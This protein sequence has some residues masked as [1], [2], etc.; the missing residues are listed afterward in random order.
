LT[1][2][3]GSER[4]PSA[5]SAGVIGRRDFLRCALAA[6]VGSTAAGRLILTDLEKRGGRLP[7]VGVAVRPPYAGP[8]D[9]LS[10]PPYRNLP[11]AST[12]AFDEAG[13]AYFLAPSGSDTRGNGSEAKPWQ[14][15][16]MAGRVLRPGDTLYMRG[17]V[18]FMHGNA[19]WFASGRAGTPI[20]VRGYP[21]ELPVVTTACREFHLDPDTAWEPVPAGDGGVAFEYRSTR[22]YSL[23]SPIIA[24]RFS[25]SFYPLFAYSLETD[26]RSENDFLIDGLEKREDHPLGFWAGPGARWNGQDGR[27]HIRLR[28]TNRKWL[29]EEDYLGIGSDFITN[30]YKGVTDPRELSLLIVGASGEEGTIKVSADH[31]RMFDMVLASH[32]K[33]EVTGSNLLFEN[34]W[35][36]TG[37]D[38]ALLS[39]ASGTRYSH[40]TFR[41]VEAPWNNRFTSKYRSNPP[42]TVHLIA[43]T[44]LEIDHCEI[45]DGHDAILCTNESPQ[46]LDFHHNLVERNSDDALFLP[47]KQRSLK[48]IYQNIFR[49][50]LSHLPFRDGAATTEGAGDGTYI[51]RNL[52]DMRPATPGRPGVEGDLQANEYYNG[53]NL[54]MEHADIVTYPGLY[55][56]HNTV[57]ARGNKR[58]YCQGITEKYDHTVRRVFNNIFVQTELRPQQIIRRSNGDLEFGFNLQWSLKMGSSGTWAGDVHAEPKF[59]KWTADWRD[60]DDFHLR[61]DSPAIGAGKKLPPEWFDPLRDLDL[62]HDMGAIPFGVRGN[63]FGPDADL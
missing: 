36:A 32:V 15:W 16:G 29:D 12:R 35:S 2:L 55:F 48:R 27:I 3:P 22:T 7:G 43:G 53:Y 37:H 52:F 63:P 11:S 18:Y 45:T 62:G 44:D 19:R 34:I 23:P 40:C 59:E 4:D 51:C 41:G 60:A 47:P 26:F 14:S 50:N 8:N 9:W 13:R 54:R 5:R 10:H 31:V 57:L 61:M 28:H 20:T 17:G 39:R 49:M 58:T 42:Y 46:N 30:N 21:G 38:S 24:G 25:D 1:R 56:Y 33:L 6:G